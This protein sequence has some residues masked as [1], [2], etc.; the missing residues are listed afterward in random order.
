VHTLATLQFHKSTILLWPGSDRTYDWGDAAW[1]FPIQNHAVFGRQPISAILI[2]R[3]SA[4]SMSARSGK[5]VTS[6]A[7]NEAKRYSYNPAGQLIQVETHDGTSYQVQAEMEYNGRGQRVSLTASQGEQSL[8]TTYRL[9]GAPA[10]AGETV[11]YHP[12][13]GDVNLHRIMKIDI[14]AWRQKYLFHPGNAGFGLC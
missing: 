1:Y 14:S 4:L 6:Q 13:I 8:S 5:L 11:Y 7:G 9:D 12:G 10:S 2:L 3:P